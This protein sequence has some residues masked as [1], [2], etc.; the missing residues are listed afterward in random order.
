MILKMNTTKPQIFIYVGKRLVAPNGYNPLP[1][2]WIIFD[3]DRYIVHLSNQIRR[4]L[5]WI[6]WIRHKLEL[7]TIHKIMKWLEKKL[8]IKVLPIGHGWN[9]C[10]RVTI[11]AHFGQNRMHWLRKLYLLMFLVSSR[12]WSLCAVLDT[13]E[14]K[15]YNTFLVK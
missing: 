7:H 14:T 9:K 1:K 15:S 8:R 11:S 2:V 12:W 5:S 10:V 6:A 4:L 13:T 3:T